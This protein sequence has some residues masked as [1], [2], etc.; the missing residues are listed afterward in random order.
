MSERQKNRLLAVYLIYVN[1][2]MRISDSL[3]RAV[4][5]IEKERAAAIVAR[6]R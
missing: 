2:G 4:A 6:V 1:A 5:D 3:K